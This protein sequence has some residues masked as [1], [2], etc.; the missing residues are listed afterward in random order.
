MREGWSR[1][2]FGLWAVILKNFKIIFRSKSAAFT[3]IFGPLIVM[4]L[5]I[6]AFNNSTLFDITI[7]SYT[8]SYSPLSNKILE[9][10]ENQSYKIIKTDS[11]D[12]CK[13]GV[14]T[15]EYHL[16]VLF[17]KDMKITNQGA[18]SL[19]FYVDNSRINIADSIISSINKEVL[20]I[21]TNLSFEL[22][23][24]LVGQLSS[25]KENLNTKGTIFD[26]LDENNNKIS[27]Q[28]YDIRNKA[29]AIDIAIDTNEFK[30]SEFRSYLLSINTTYK[31]TDD[32][33]NGL[34]RRINIGET[35]A[36]A[37]N[38]K[39]AAA[40]LKIGEV[41][42]FASKIPAVVDANKDD[43]N[44]VQSSIE[45]VVKKINGISVTNT[46]SIVSPIKTNIETLDA[47]TTHIGRFLPAFLV[48]FVMFVCILLASSI[49]LSEK[50]SSAYFR[51]AITALPASIFLISIY[52]T[53]LLVI[54]FQLFIVAL[55]L[56]FFGG[57]SVSFLISISFILLLIVSLF[58]LIGISIGYF[59]KSQESA[60][61]FS[62]VIILI[63]LFFSNTI[64]PLES[65]PLS[66]K[67]IILFNPFVIAEAALKKIIIF[68]FTVKEVSKNIID[69]AIYNVIL[70][71]ISYIG[72]IRSK[73]QR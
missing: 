57:Y 14:K 62:L 37:I 26:I 33:Y 39:L 34:R 25:T 28:A 70:L 55:F 2:L 69:L 56:K 53:S 21:S 15:G 61:V 1:T 3:I 38:T 59:S 24:V 65:I 13:L 44:K 11:L 9:Q 71:I 4:G 52:I 54:L 32:D 36:T 5:I 17:P 60:N 72:F 48:L 68:G 8:E 66:L 30:F 51:N 7:A 42:S 64:L 67:N 23:D 20:K 40:K 27:D 73:I 22:T 6:M 43:L 49:V 29:N 16:C 50:T 45:E 46:E 58:I 47:Q 35:Y 18:N 10:L 41:S 63:L 12:A 31:F 19:T